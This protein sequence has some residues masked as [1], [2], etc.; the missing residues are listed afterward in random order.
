MSDNNL[1]Q[2]LEN[3]QIKQDIFKKIK[4]KIT[5]DVDQKVSESRTT[6]SSSKLIF[7]ASPN[8]SSIPKIFRFQ[9]EKLLENGGASISKFML[10]YITHLICGVNYDENEVSQAQELYEIPAL[11]EKWVVASAKLGKSFRA[12]SL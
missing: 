5:G 9:I 3:L 10:D 7:F 8:Y 2:N 12:L 6:P 1:H 11:T 4:V